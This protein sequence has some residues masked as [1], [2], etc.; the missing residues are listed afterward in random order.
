MIFIHGGGWR[1]GTRD[2]FQRQA[3]H[4]AERG[5]VC[6][7]ISYRLSGEATFPAALEDCKCAV[8][9]LKAQ[10]QKYDLDTSRI[11]AVGGSAGGHLAA[12]VAVSHANAELEGEGGHP[13]LSSQVHAAAAFNG[14]FD[15]VDAGKKD[16]AKRSLVSFLGGDYETVPE[17]YAKASPIRYIDTTSPPFLLFHGTADTTVPYQQSVDFKQALRNVGVTVSLVTAQDQKHGY[18]NSSPHF[19]STL[20]RLETFLDRELRGP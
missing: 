13:E 1:G 20:E 7:C 4:L 6:A 17:L 11:A 10:S 19:E 16:P 15:L 9:W 2:H 18:F 8:R 3:V 5:Y 14:A 12:L